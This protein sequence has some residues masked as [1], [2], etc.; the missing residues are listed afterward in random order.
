MS[1]IDM[2]TN[3]GMTGGGTPT[4]D[5]PLAV[6]G[7][8]LVGVVNEISTAL[9]SATSDTP[10]EVLIDP[11]AGTLGSEEGTISGV[12]LGLSDLGNVLVSD[13]S[14]LSPLTSD[15]LA[16]LVGTSPDMSTDNGVPGVLLNTGDA[17]TTL[18][19]SN[20]ALSLLDPVTEGVSDVLL[21]PLADGVEMIGQTLLDNSAQDPSGVVDLLGQLLGG[22]QGA[23]TTSP[24]QTTTS[25][26]DALSFIFDPFGR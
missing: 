24:I 21:S 10:L 26:V 1:V 4:T 12:A 13:Q 17:L 22:D 3:G 8:G 2:P 23:G 7:N 14:V 15:V 5:S 9:D 16:P 6:P 25:P 20:S 18:T 19:S 11:L